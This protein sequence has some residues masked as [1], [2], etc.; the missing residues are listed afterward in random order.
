MP[1]FV[2]DM[3]VPFRRMIMCHMFADTDDELHAM[4]AR[5]GVARRWHQRPE[6]VVLGV[7]VP[8]PGMVASW[9]HYDIS[10]GMRA[11]ALQYGA[12]AMRWRDLPAWLKERGR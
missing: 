10:Q 3:R 2:D 5:I 7:P 8:T 11:R 9:S 1:V 12:I 4:A 6:L